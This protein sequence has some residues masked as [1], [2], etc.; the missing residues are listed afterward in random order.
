[1]YRYKVEGLK[2]GDVVET[3]VSDPFPSFEETPAKTHPDVSEKREKEDAFNAAYAFG[4]KY[5]YNG[6]FIGLALASL[7]PETGGPLLICP[8]TEDGKTCQFSVVE[9]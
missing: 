2:N 7:G 9:G 1:M 4:T 8:E 3:F 5:H 6:S